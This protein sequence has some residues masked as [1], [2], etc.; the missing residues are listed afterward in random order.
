[1][2][3]RNGSHLIAPAIERLLAQTPTPTICLLD[4]QSH[5]GTPRVLERLARAHPEIQVRRTGAR[6]GPVEACRRAAALVRE[7]HPDAALF[8]W[9]GSEDQPGPDWLG[10]LVRAL[11]RRSQRV[12]AL[13][14]GSGRPLAMRDV[15]DPARRAALALAHRWP[16]LP[17]G[18]VFRL[19]A[20]LSAGGLRSVAN[21]AGVLG[22]E[23]ALAGELVTVDHC[24]YDRAWGRGGLTEAYPNGIP[25]AAVLPPRA[26][27][28]LS[29]SRHHGKGGAV[30][31][32]QLSRD[33]RRVGI[34]LRRTPR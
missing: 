10:P 4:D 25:V 11:L 27:A 34:P 22:A 33:L 26:A 13:P 6:V 31:R 12:A 5:D 32:R 16:P 14:E 29:L 3:V 9:V 7:L 18:I 2:P 30:L 1:M 21:P 24:R 19:D 23:V 20:V 28:F 15:T 17:T 8:A